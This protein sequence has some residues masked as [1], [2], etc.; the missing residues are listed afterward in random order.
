MTDVQRDA[1]DRRVRVTIQF[2]ASRLS[3]VYLVAAYELIV[4]VRGR[5][6]VREHGSQDRM[7]TTREGRGA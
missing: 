7:P 4:P 5:P 1:E 2:E 6:T 3:G